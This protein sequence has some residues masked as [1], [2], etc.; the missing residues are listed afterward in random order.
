M[1]W[2]F[3]G[4][5]GIFPGQPAEDHR[6]RHLRQSPGRSPDLHG[7]ESMRIQST[8][9]RISFAAFDECVT[10]PASTLCQGQLPALAAPVAGALQGE[11]DKTMLCPIHRE[12]RQMLFGINRGRP[13]RTCGSGTCGDRQN[14]LR[15]LRHRRTAVKPTEVMYQI[16]EAPRWSYMP[17]TSPGISW[18]WEL[19]ATSSGVARGVDFF[20]CHTCP[21]ATLLLASHGHPS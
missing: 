1:R 21:N 11:H 5:S 20:D 10:N 15:R 7:P 4:S 19:P 3:C 13:M 9:A 8:W 17:A 16:I 6:R 2:T 12:P 14:R 18:A